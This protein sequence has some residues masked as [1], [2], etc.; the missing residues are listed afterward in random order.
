MN[1]GIFIAAGNWLGFLG[2]LGYALKASLPFFPPFTTVFEPVYNVLV[3]LGWCP[4]SYSFLNCFFLPFWFVI[5][6]I[7][8]AQFSPAILEL[9]HWRMHPIWDALTPHHLIWNIYPWR[10]GFDRSVVYGLQ[11]SLY[12]SFRKDGCTNSWAPQD[13]ANVIPWKLWCGIR[14]YQNVKVL[15]VNILNCENE[16]SSRHF[17]LLQVNWELW[18]HLIVLTKTPNLTFRIWFIPIL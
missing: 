8:Q 17:S 4:G 10:Q 15:W 13:W 7:F 18:A 11:T 12:K 5:E 16:F 14:T 2:P 9:V 3:C 6:C 1:K